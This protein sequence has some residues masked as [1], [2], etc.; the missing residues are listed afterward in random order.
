MRNLPLLALLVAA[1][2]GDTDDSTDE[3]GLAEGD[4]DTDTDAD[5]D[6]DADTDT[7]TDS[8]ADTDPIAQVERVGVALV[9]G[10]YDGTEEIVVTGDNGY[11]AVI[12]HATMSL[13]SV[14]P[15]R[16]DCTVCDWAYDLEIGGATIDVDDN[17]ACM[18]TIGVDATT[19][20]SWD[21]TVRSYGYNPDYFGHAQ[22]L[23]YWDGSAWV[24]VSYASWDEAKHTFDYQWSDG[25]VYY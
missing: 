14:G 23:V 4:A 24:T 5:S 1:C 20:G 21:G 10:G 8:D 7:D 18:A 25:A 15:E 17:G 12:C 11:G 6:T 16:T 13:V 19:I 2:G 9:N 3:T 22:A